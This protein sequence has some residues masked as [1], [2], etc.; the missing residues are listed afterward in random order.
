ML[1]ENLGIDISYVVIGLAAL[2]LLLFLLVVVNMVKYSKLK[3]RYVQFLTGREGQSLE[4]ILKNVVKDVDAVKVSNQKVEKAMQRV[5]KDVN[6]CYSK[7][8][9]V[10]YDAFK[11]LA[12]K[13]SFSM[14]ML[15]AKKNGYVTTLSGRRRPIPELKSSN[16]MQ[17]SFGE[18]IAM[19]SPIQGTAA[20]IIKIAMINVDRELCFRFMMN[21]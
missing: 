9:I 7:I 12:G 20:D 13:L 14:A 15:D 8:G 2:V 10:R 18:R 11:G 5:E 16:F 6:D 19:N 3:K 17:R 4:E 21:C 1:F